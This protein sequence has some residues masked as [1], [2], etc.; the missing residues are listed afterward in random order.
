MRA[1]TIIKKVT[2]DDQELS[3]T[4]YEVKTNS[5]TDELTLVVKNINLGIHKTASL[6]VDTKVSDVNKRETYRTIGYLVGKDDS[7][8]DIQKISA[9]R[10]LNLTTNK[11]EYTIKDIDYGSIKPIGND[12]VIFRQNNESNWPDNVMDVDDMRRDKTPIT[13]SVSQDSDFVSED[14]KNTLAGHLKFFDDDY[15]QDLLTGSAIISQTKSGQEMTSLSWQADKGILLE[16]D[17]KQLNATGNYETKL[18]W[19]FTDSI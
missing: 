10:S 18:N 17:N 3:D 19:V 6:V 13:L 1:G 16:L 14:S 12:Q 4:D 5:D 11:L 15:E 7:G 8:N 9:P 2:L